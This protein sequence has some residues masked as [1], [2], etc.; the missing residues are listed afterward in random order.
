MSIQHGLQPAG[1]V[2]WTPRTNCLMV[3][4][5]VPV[6]FECSVS[7]K[8]YSRRVVPGDVH[9]IPQGTELG[10]QLSGSTELVLLT[11][12]HVAL[13]AVARDVSTNSE[14]RLTF[15]FSLR[16]AQILSLVHTLQE[17]LKSGC[18]TGEFY[19]RQLGAA[20]IGYVAS[21]YSTQGQHPVASS[22]G[23]PPNRLRF[24]LDHI[25]S[26]LETRL[27]LAELAAKARMSPQHFANLFRRSMGRA[28]HEY[29]VH[30]RIERAKRLLAETT[31]PLM[32]VAFEVGFANQSHFTDVFH[33][34]TGMTPRRY[35]QRF[36]DIARLDGPKPPRSAESL[37]PTR[38]DQRSGP[39][40]S[41]CLKEATAF[42]TVLRA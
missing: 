1:R 37:P 35:R 8:T 36:E 39:A 18:V 40:R 4:L 7:G 27:E 21:R 34:L 6:T 31:E 19:V 23:L 33:R 2:S 5:A 20:L 42:S 30:E 15:Q 10:I 29:V 26:H 38:R 28:P 32:D 12:D 14:L 24:V 3:H 16:D 13:Q 41:S 11:F 25:H 9:I 17:E 22:G